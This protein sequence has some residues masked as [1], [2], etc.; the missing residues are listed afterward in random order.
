[1]NRRDLLIEIGTEELPPKALKQLSAAFCD[2]LCQSLSA[3]GCQHGTVTPYAAPRRLAVLIKDVPT[4]T[5]VVSVEVWGPPAR[6][7]FDDKGE[8]TKAGLA[9]AD[10]NGLKADQ[11]I[12]K[13]DGKADKLFAQIN[14]GGDAIA[15]LIPAMV[16]DALNALPIPKRMRWGAKREEFVRPVHWLVM[17]MGDEVIE[18]SVMGLTAGRETR[19]HRFHCNRT[20]VLEKATDYAAQLQSPGYVMA[21][22]DARQKTI[23]QQVNDQA[24]RLGGVAQMDPA[25]LDE[26]TALVEWPVALAGKFEERFLA[27]PAEALISSMGEHQKYFHVLDKDGKLMPYFITVAN[28]ESKDPAQVIDGNERVI[29]PRL[30]DAAFFF[31]T[32]KKTRLDTQRERLKTIVFQA[33]LGTL[34]DKTERIA[35]L[36]HVIAER[37]GAD[38]AAARRAAELCKS[39]LVTNM[40]GEFDTMQGIAGY[41]YALNDGE[42][43]EVAKAL[44][45]QYL[46]RF[47][48]D[49]LPETTTGTVL[50]LADRLDTL[51]GIFGIGQLPTGSKDPF[52]LRRASL[53][54]LRLLVEKQLPLDLKALVQAAIEQ[55]QPL[56]EANGLVDQVVGYMLERFRAWYEEASIATEVFL[57]V[58]AKSLT[59][60]LDID[61]RVQA[62]HAFSQLPE[63]QALAAANKRVGNILAKLDS[64]PADAIDTDLLAEPAEKALAE[65][66]AAK[67]ASTQPLFDQSEY[68][69][70]LTNLADLQAPVDAFFDQVMVMA[71]DDAL[72]NNRL[73]LLQQLRAL[74]LEVADISQLVPAKA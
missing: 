68:K 64:L 57:S 48:G 4:Q 8:L 2:S 46:P 47:A 9:F 14:K 50:A 6:I 44:N 65:A 45:E 30:S 12:T 53:G 41:Y 20:L 60:P 27:V 23:V 1:M 33:Q 59:Q 10:K 67:R 19:G 17:L 21:D 43:E 32:D 3:A 16:N 25:L 40:V 11:L 63:A 7:A 22:F 73:A 49:A 5:P 55:H 37:L 42:S 13:N 39:D 26:V 35:G 34:Y 51:V 36:A 29:R 31:E 71:D 70:A 28:L 74:F 38:A 69:L 52:A 66:I 58:A 62:V 56:P 54:V 18:G 61:N 15:Q 24:K 72:R